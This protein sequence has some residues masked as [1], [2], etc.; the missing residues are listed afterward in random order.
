[1]DKHRK[2]PIWQ[3]TPGQSIFIPHGSYNR[4]YSVAYYIS[5][6]TGHKYKLRSVVK[7][8]I[9]GLRIICLGDKVE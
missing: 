2:S 5:K 3:L 8:G 6:V 4:H 9:E 7:G 1:M